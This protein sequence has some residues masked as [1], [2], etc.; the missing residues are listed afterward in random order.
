V[1]WVQ[2]PRGPAVARDPEFKGLLLA[3]DPSQRYVLQIADV[4]RRRK[5][6]L[7]GAHA[8]NAYVSD[9]PRTTKDVDFL[10]PDAAAAKR[11]ADA[12]LAAM[13]RLSRRD[14]S[15]GMVQILYGPKQIKIAD[16]VPTDEPLT[17]AALAMASRKPVPGL[18][19]LLVPPA[20]IIVALKMDSA[21]DP[22]RE[23][24]RARQDIADASFV[25]SRTKMDVRAL[26]AALACVP[27]RARRLYEKLKKEGW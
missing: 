5:H 26:D 11:A 25:L 16:L 17:M 8:R 7:F 6:A 27:P 2:R 18:G 10:V 12:I 13:P 19:S 14:F 4:M 1:Q 24:S 3:L 23:P 20:E 15:F 22:R 21:S 9:D